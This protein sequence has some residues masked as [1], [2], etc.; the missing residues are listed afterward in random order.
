[1][2][3]FRNPAKAIQYSITMHLMMNECQMKWCTLCFDITIVL[4]ILAIALKENNIYN[5]KC[6]ICGEYNLEN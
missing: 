6:N 4:F 2:D 1:M 3:V 5:Q